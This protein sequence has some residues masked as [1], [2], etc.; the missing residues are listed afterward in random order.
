MTTPFLFET[1]WAPSE[2]TPDTIPITW[3]KVQ[4]IYAGLCHKIGAADIAIDDLRRVLC[5]GQLEPTIALRNVRDLTGA[6]WQRRDL[7]ADFWR[8]LPLRPR[9]DDAGR[10]V[11]GFSAA[12]LNEAEKASL[13]RGGIWYAQ[14]ARAN[15]ELGQQPARGRRSPRGA[16]AAYD[17][18]EAVIEASHYMYQDDPP[19]DQLVKHI[20]AWFGESPPSETQLRDHLRPVFERFQKPN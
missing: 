6:I 4:E 17:W 10:N 19:F 16:K 12:N 8:R 20:E 2:C 15:A 7:G 11:L 18:E 9:I 1:G 14:L 13:S 5:A 3:I